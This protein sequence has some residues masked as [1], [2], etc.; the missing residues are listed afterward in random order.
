MNQYD[1]IY[2]FRKLDEVR[3]ILEELERM[4][5]ETEDEHTDTRD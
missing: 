4:V 2:F 1:K 5:E 3:D